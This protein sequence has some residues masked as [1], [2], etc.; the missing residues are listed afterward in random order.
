MKTSIILG[1]DPGSVKSGWVLWDTGQ[2]RP[3]LCGHDDNQILLGSIVDHLTAIDMV[4]IEMLSG[5]GV[6]SGDDTFQTC[7]WVG[8]FEQASPVPV[9]LITRKDIKRHLCGNT[10]TNDKYLRQALIDRFG[11]VGT[12]K[13]PGPLFG[14]S[15]HIWAALGVAVTAQDKN[16]EKR[17]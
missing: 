10:T 8:R 2:N 3:T 1:I 7:R 12:K 11:E 13:G 4:A 17:E 5:Y 9:K 14:V 15:G 6:V 16:M